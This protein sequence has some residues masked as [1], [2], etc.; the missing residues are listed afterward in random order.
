[1]IDQQL[2]CNKFWVSIIWTDKPSSANGQKSVESSLKTDASL[3]GAADGSK[4]LW[5]PVDVQSSLLVDVVLL[6]EFRE[7]FVKISIGV[8]IVQSQVSLDDFFGCSSGVLLSDPEVSSWE[9]VGSSLGGVVL[10]H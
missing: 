8:L 5:H 3:V 6:P 1:M 10:V 4:E 7:H 2:Q 9:A